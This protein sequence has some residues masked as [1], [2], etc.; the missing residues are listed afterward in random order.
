MFFIENRRLDNKSQNRK[1]PDDLN[2]G[3]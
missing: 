2:D 3:L 1:F